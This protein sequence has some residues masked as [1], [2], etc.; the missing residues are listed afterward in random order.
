MRRS[1]NSTILES[2]GDVKLWNRHFVVLSSKIRSSSDS[3]GA[4]RTETWS[5]TTPRGW[6]NEEEEVKETEK[7]YQWGWEKIFRSSCLIS[8]EES[9]NSNQMNQTLLIMQTRSL[10]IDLWINNKKRTSLL[11]FI[12]RGSLGRWDWMYYWIALKRQ[13]EYR[14]WKIE[15]FC[16]KRAKRRDQM[17]QEKF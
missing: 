8:Q 17:T 11:M 2:R 3:E 5:I 14:N 4:L 13:W 1:L 9:G 15:E 12:R 16:F 7:K 10:R 6:A